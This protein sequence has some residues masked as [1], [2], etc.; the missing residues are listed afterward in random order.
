MAQAEFD[1]S[2]VGSVCEARGGRRSKDWRAVP[3]V[4][5]A[6]VLGLASESYAA[7]IF[8]PVPDD[9][10]PKL[11]VAGV[12]GRLAA[13]AER[14]V[15]IAHHELV[16]AREA[17]ENAGAGRVLLNVGEGVNLDVVVER[18]AP[19]RWGYSLSGRVA[20]G[21][22]GFVTLVVHEE[23][24]AGSIWTPDSAYELS[25]IG[26][27]VHALRDVTDAPSVGCAGVQPGESPVARVRERTAMEDGSDGSVV[28]ILVVWT[29]RAEADA[30]GDAQ[31]VS[32]IALNVAY[33]NDAFERS[34]AFVRLSLVGAEKVDYVEAGTAL[35]DL[36][37]LISPDDGYMDGVH[38]RRDT[39]GAD[40]VSLYTDAGYGQFLGPFSLASGERTFAHEIGH[41]MGL[42]HDRPNFTPVASYGHGFTTTVCLSSIMSRGTVCHGRGHGDG[43]WPFY[44]SPWRYSADGRALGVARF[45]EERGVLGPADAVLALNRNRHHVANFRPS[46]TESNRAHV[47]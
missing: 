46:A 23:V 28:D 38:D 15:R 32:R 13:G 16:A 5:G 1:R 29:P 2:A 22:V 21:S 39:L 33:A 12:G 26:G 10:P 40:L 35:T 18:T 43:G 11:A 3:V 6:V 24:V 8:L 44:A 47:E 14:R 34:G 42:H 17:V 36:R 27:G 20:G 4:L 7:G 45:A 25:Y 30:G 9:A 37:R 41:N 31:V 19:T